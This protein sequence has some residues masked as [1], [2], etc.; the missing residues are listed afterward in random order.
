M[1]TRNDVTGLLLAVSMLACTS[2][3]LSGQ[4]SGR[5]AEATRPLHAAPEREPLAPELWVSGFSSDAI[6]R[7]DQATGSY[8]SNHA[9]VP[10]AQSI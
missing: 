5:L 1:S 8:L 4:A 7:Y 10:G 2:P 6:H 9:P 3:A